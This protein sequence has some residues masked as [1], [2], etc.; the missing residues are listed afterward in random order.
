MNTLATLF[1]LCIAHAVADY[2]LQSQYV[3]D[4]KGRN[5]WVMLAHCLIH[6]GAV[7][8]VTCNPGLGM[9]EVLLHAAIDTAK[10]RRITNENT[11]QALHYG[12]KVAYVAVIWGM[13]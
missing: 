8:A 1:A 13:A 3:A 5:R 11:D 6:G 4:H 12:C 10:C 9:V 7:W 2:G